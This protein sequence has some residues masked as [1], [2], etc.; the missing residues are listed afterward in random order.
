M[1]DLIAQDREYNVFIAFYF[2][3][4]ISTFYKYDRY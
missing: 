2:Q 3:V 4:E 1:S